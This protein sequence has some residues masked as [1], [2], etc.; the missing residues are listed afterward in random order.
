MTFPP[1]AGLKTKNKTLRDNRRD[2]AKT[3]QQEERE[4]KL[5]EE[6]LP[7]NPPEPKLLPVGSPRAQPKCPAILA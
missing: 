2:H 1:N 7:I 4:V 3:K 5:L 6:F